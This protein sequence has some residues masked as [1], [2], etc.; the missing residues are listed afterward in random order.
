MPLSS[1]Q[2]ANIPAELKSLPQWVGWKLVQRDGKAT[3]LPVNPKTGDLASSTDPSTWGTI[4]EALIATEKYGL[5]GI[6]FA[7][8]EHDSFCGVDLDSCR[9][10]ET[11]EVELW[12]QQHIDRF[13]SYT[14]TSPSGKGVH[15]ILK[16][17]LPPGG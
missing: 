5:P 2:I 17:T 13:N 12:A 8:S 3:K 9:N 7:F 16:G 10:P 6:G 14:E 1:L 4:Q 11:G 15:I